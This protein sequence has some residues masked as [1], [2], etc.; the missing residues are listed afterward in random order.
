MS[1]GRGTPSSERG[2]GSIAY[3]LIAVGAL[4][5]VIQLGWFDWRLLA[6]ISSYW[7]IFLVAAGI[8]LLTRGRN[9]LALYGGAAVL[10]LVLSLFGGFSAGEDRVVQVAQELEGASAAD[11][12]LRAGVARMT[13]TSDRSATLLAEGRLEAVA[14]QEIDQSYARRGQRGR[15]ELASRRLRGFRGATSAPT[16]QLQLSG[17]VPI[18]LHV[19]SGVGNANMDL[20]ELQLESL[21]LDGGVGNVSLTLPPR[22]DYRADI[23]G[24]VGDTVVRLPR[25][26]AARISV[27]RGVGSVRVPD[28]FTRD[29][30]VYTSPGYDSAPDRVDLRID[31]GVGSVRIEFAD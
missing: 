20:S 17:R 30:D 4:L 1:D 16:W 18:A 5:L 23:D 12:R 13:L 22:G 10:V 9:R 19:D 3:I 27:D 29:D 15:L 14:G 8:D 6:G 24:G 25:G 26:L 31:G 21:Q 28:V 7:P 2:G 11:V